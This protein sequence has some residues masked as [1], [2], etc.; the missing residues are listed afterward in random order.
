MKTSSKA[1]KVSEYENDNLFDFCRESK[2]NQNYG[3]NGSISTSTNKPLRARRRCKSTTPEVISTNETEQS[4]AGMKQS[5]S[6]SK[7]I[8]KEYKKV[9]ETVMEKRSDDDDDFRAQNASKT[10]RAVAVDTRMMLHDMSFEEEAGIRLF[11]RETAE[12]LKMCARKCFLPLY[13]ACSGSP[14]HC[15]DTVTTEVIASSLPV[16]LLTGWACPKSSTSEQEAWNAMLKPVI[17]Q[18]RS[19]QSKEF[20]NRST[21]DTWHLFV[22]FGA[23]FL[24]FATTS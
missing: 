9:V 8:A 22:D 17:I 11:L 10:R 20:K 1:K 12:F 2:E 19:N 15:E 14:L 21:R 18:H 23:S 6:G 5:K 3:G 7:F 13:F 24:T 16:Q 4:D